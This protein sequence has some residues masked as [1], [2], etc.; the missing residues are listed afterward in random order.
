[1]NDPQVGR[2]RYRIAKRPDVS[3][4][5][6][7]PTNGYEFDTFTLVRE[8]YNVTIEMKEHFAHEREAR[9]HVERRL[10]EWEVADALHWGRQEFRFEFQQADLVDRQP[11]DSD[12]QSIETRTR[13][14]SS[15][16]L[17]I[18]IHDRRPH[19]PAP[20]RRP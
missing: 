17:P 5:P 7:P 16:G 20:P 14:V 8:E 1:M 19:F 12:A 6:A 2:L 18:D 4:E 15:Y 9:D 3:Y 11:A 13:V 10:R